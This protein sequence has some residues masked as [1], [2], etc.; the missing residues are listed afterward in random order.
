[1]GDF[2]KISARTV[3]QISEVDPAH[4][5]ACA[6]PD[7]GKHNPFVSHAFLRALEASGSVG[8]GTGWMAQHLLV[9]DDGGSL[10]GVMPLYLKTDSQGEYVFDHAWAEALHR[11]GGRYY[12]KLQCAVPFTPVPG[13][14]L[15]ARPGPG[16]ETMQRVLASAAVG[17]AEQIG[18][19]SLHITFAT[20]EEWALLG[21]MG[22]LQRIGQQFH[23]RNEGYSSFDDFLATLA[24]RKRKA[25]RKER[26]EAHG[27]GLAIEQ[28]SGAQI[29]EAHWDAFF[30]FYLETGS[31]KWGRPYLNRA[32]FSLL[33]EAQGDRC[34][35]I[36][37]KRAGRYVA[38]ALHLIGGDCLFGRYW[39][40]IEHHPF[41]HFEL[42]YYQGI[43]YAIAHGLARA[44]AGAQGEHKLARGYLPEATYS[45]HWIREPRLEAAVRRYLE[46]ERAEMTT[47]VEVL[48]AQGPYRHGEAQRDD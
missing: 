36:M 33:G 25:V 10:G 19:S 41:L 37:A 35:L 43:E 17:A 32:F 20:E 34:L 13:R 2:D 5:D 7:V 6:N 22:F 21:G 48:R 8:P 16:A 28:L 9:S 1:M 27:A 42:C 23:W 40:A 29:M 24:S 18:C 14:R 47:L 45:L 26:A 4:W 15:L 11:V 38:G 39:G 44:E 3:P 46:A 30:D 12:P 31:R